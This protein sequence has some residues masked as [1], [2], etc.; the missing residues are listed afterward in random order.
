MEIKN[1]N[2]KKNC[3]CVTAMLLMLMSSG[4]AV[5][6]DIIRPNDT[7]LESSTISPRKDETEWAFRI[8]PD[9]GVLEKRLWSITYGVWR[10]EWE[11][12]V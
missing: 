10:T 11:P 3:L 12:V 6:A 9:T 8:N 1:M 4:I 2:L 5:H 7:V